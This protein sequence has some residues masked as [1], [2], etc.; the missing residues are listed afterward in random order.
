MARFAY[1]VIFLDRN[2]L[3]TIFVSQISAIIL[4]QHATLQRTIY[5]ARTE[6]IGRLGEGGTT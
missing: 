6:N 3:Y 1:C 2:N 4:V 5:Q